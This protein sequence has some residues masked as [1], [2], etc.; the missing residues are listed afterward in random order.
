M[1]LK[2][3]ADINSG[4]GVLLYAVGFFGVLLL[5]K[6]SASVA[7][8]VIGIEAAWT[9][10]LGEYLLKRHGKDKVSVDRLK[11]DGGSGA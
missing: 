3:K 10:G 1:N 11:V 5:T 6:Y 4:G 7:E 9:L 2:F 8:N